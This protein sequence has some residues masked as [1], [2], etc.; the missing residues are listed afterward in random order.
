M[1]KKLLFV[2]VAIVVILLAVAYFTPRNFSLSKSIT[3]NAPRET[4]YDYVRFLSSQEKYSVWVMADPNIA[5]Q[6]TGTDGAVGATSSW[7]S[8]MKNVGVGAQTITALVPNE[9]MTVEIRFEKP[10]KA[11]NYADTTLE[12]VGGQT[13]VTNTFYGTNKFPMNI[14][15][16]FLDKIIG[17]DIEKNMENLKKNLESSDVQAAIVADPIVEM[18]QKLVGTWQNNAEAERELILNNDGTYSE[19]TLSGTW[20][21]FTKQNAPS[22]FSSIFQNL[23]D[24]KI[25]LLMVPSQF[26]V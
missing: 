13:K 12:V 19:S 24:S 23:E 4:V 7:K 11:T 17:G 15:N 22:E 16:L 14:T 5:M 21:L 26:D 25:Y 1:I 18:K 6:Y 10:M 9:K 2:L 20:S 3:I 8:E